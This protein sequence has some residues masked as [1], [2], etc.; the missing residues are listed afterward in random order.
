MWEEN[1]V[2]KRVGLIAFDSHGHRPRSEGKIGERVVAE[3]IK[4]K[5]HTHTNSGSYTVV[6]E[7]RQ[8]PKRFREIDDARQAASDEYEAHLRELASR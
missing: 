6:V 5:N 4:N 1:L 2:V 8:L 7:G 3:I